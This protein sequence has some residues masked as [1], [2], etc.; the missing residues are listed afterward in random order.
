MF[1]FL[2]VAMVLRPTL[3]DLKPLQRCGLLTMARSGGAG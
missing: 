2:G 3:G 1:V